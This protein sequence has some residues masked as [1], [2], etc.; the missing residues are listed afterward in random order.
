MQE[1]GAPATAQTPGLTERNNGIGL[2]A[3]PEVRLLQAVGVPAGHQ[4]LVRGKAE[5]EL[6]D[7]CCSHWTYPQER[8]RCLIQLN[9]D[10]VI[11]LVIQNHVTEKVHLHQGLRLGTIAPVSLLPSDGGRRHFPKLTLEPACE[12]AATAGGA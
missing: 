12:S 6:G 2:T 4:K 7:V 5:R 11:T 1:Q 10:K 3:E 8:C 9:K